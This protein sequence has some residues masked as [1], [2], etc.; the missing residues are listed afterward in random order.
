M[1]SFKAKLPSFIYFKLKYGPNK[2]DWNTLKCVFDG[3]EN[4]ELFE[5]LIEREK[6]LIVDD[7]VLEWLLENIEIDK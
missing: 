6:E 5:M 3:C 7:I 4:P 2:L 1:V